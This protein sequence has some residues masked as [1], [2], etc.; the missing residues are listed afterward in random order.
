[1]NQIVYNSSIS[2]SPATPRDTVSCVDHS[3]STRLVES[4]I[5]GD[6]RAGD[7]LVKRHYMEITRFFMTAVGDQERRDLTQETFTRLCSAKTRFD[8]RSSFRGFL[9]GIARNVLNES[10]RKR[11]RS[12]DGGPFDPQQHTIADV[13]QVTASRLL[14]ELVRREVMVQCLR[15]LPVET[16]QLME[17]F[18]WHGLT[19]NELS[20]TYGV[21]APTIRTRLFNS[22]ARLQ[23]AVAG[24]EPIL[25]DIN[26]EQ[27]LEVLRKLLG[28][29]PLLMDQPEA[30]PPK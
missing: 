16:K 2:S 25:G 4:W 17:M 15:E 3:D 19:A 11:Y 7:L 8:K 9:Y 24:R 6:R 28:F 14:S 10:L 21:P 1:M 26:V 30:D 18:Y 20:D 27:Q 13:G 5:D 23:K 29:G 22:K 12:K